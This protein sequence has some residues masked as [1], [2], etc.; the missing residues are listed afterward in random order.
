MFCEMVGSMPVTLSQMY[1]NPEERKF[2]HKAGGCNDDFTKL[3]K[4]FCY[5]TVLLMS[6]GLLVV[7]PTALRF[8]SSYGNAVV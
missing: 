5:E 3:L 1:V 8:L 4:T 7:A 6:L 2:R